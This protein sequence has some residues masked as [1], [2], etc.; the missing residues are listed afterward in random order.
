MLFVS[1]L[2]SGSP[3]NSWSDKGFPRHKKGKRRKRRLSEDTK[4]VLISEERSRSERRS[5]PVVLSV[6][7]SWPFLTAGVDCGGAFCLLV[8]T[9]VGARAPSVSL[10][11][12][13]C[14][15]V[16][17]LPL[18]M[19][20]FAPSSSLLGNSAPFI[21]PAS[22]G[23]MDSFDWLAGMLGVLAFLRNGDA[24]SPM[25]RSTSRYR[26]LRSSKQR[27]GSLMAVGLYGPRALMRSQPKPILY[28]ISSV[29]IYTRKWRSKYKGLM[30]NMGC[31]T[32][33]SMVKTY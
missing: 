23:W 17:E 10:A 9:L 6:P 1:F 8:P 29:F 27:I 32:K 31:P 26:S 33:N 21:V 13:P 24:W 28:R 2:I 25:F 22:F 18:K 30:R 3:K 20:F 15:K 19:G 7:P 12:S 16:A 11:E 5:S 14:S 4:G